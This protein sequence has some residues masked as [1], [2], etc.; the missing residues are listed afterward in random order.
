MPGLIEFLGPQAGP[1]F[2][3]LKS[4]IVLT[5]IINAFDFYELALNVLESFL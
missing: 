1:Y 4:N 5:T 2:S 3:L